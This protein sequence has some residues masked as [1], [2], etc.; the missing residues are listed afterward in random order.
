MPPRMF[1]GALAALLM[2]ALL[3][4]GCN[5]YE[6][7]YEEGASDDPEV[8]LE[9]AR[10]ALQRNE[11]A[12]AAG[13]LRKALAQTAEGS[14][15]QKRVQI[16]LASAVLQT[17]QIDALSLSQMARTFSG[18]GT[19]STAK[20]QG[21]VCNFPA[22]HERALFDPTADIDFER[23]GSTESREARTEAA[24]LITRVF[25]HP[26]SGS[27][28][29]FPCDD[30]GMD[31]AIADLQHHGL[32]D[33]E[34]AEALVD[35]AVVVS[36][37][38]YLDVVAAGGGEATFYYVAA[39]GGTEYVGTC[40]PEAAACEATLDRTAANLPQLDCSTRLL[41]KRAVLLGSSK[42]TELADLARDGYQSLE[43]GLGAATCTA[44]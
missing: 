27:D 15:L 35:Y 36:T 25:S 43:A 14:V 2:A 33:A 6:G 4:A 20:H 1:S 10:I 32:T 8:L 29:V 19:G 18:E 22:T 34:I 31:A 13:H 30:A 38:S 41:Q 42:A 11:P 5:V 23:L 12:T 28:A 40:F 16:K 24:A 37:E 21:P 7:L 26:G 17:E 39:P 44:H 9:D 3:V